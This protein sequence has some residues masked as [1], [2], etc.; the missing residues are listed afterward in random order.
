MQPDKIIVDNKIFKYLFIYEITV[1]TIM[2]I[3]FMNIRFNPFNRKITVINLFLFFKN[4]LK[5]TFY[6]IKV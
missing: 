3:V 6:D 2:L 5:S 1:N 4:Q